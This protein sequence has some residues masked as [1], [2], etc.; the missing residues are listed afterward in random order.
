[1][2]DK[3]TWAESDY[4]MLSGWWTAWG[5][6]PV[7]LMFLPKTGFIVSIEGR[8]ICASWLYCSDTPICWHENFISDKEA[9]RGDRDGALD[10]L[11]ESM[12]EQARAMGF[13]AMFC[14]LR[15]NTLIRRMERHGFTATD[16]GMTHMI[17]G[18]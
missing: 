2:F 7:P 10:F 16:A 15:H 12:D 1:M 4:E 8:D 17:K 11:I 18:L 3:R 14:A 6:N 5:W 9:G 13:S